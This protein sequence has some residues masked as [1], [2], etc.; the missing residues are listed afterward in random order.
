MEDAL[1]DLSY[2]DT[3][4][5]QL[6][7]KQQH[8]QHQQQFQ[9]QVHPQHQAPSRPQR[10]PQPSNPVRTSQPHMVRPAAAASAPHAHADEFDA[11]LL[12]DDADVAYLLSL[13]EA[14]RQGVL[15]LRAE[16]RKQAQ[17]NRAHSALA[18]RVLASGKSFVP[19][20][21]ASKK[22]QPAASVVFRSAGDQKE[23]EE[24]A[25][26]EDFEDYDED[27]DDEDYEDEDEEDEDWEGDYSDEDEEDA[28]ARAV[29]GAEAGMTLYDG[30]ALAVEDS[31][32]QQQKKQLKQ[33]QQALEKM[34]QAA[35]QQKNKQQQQKQAQ[36]HQ[37][38]QAQQKA[39]PK[40]Q[41][42]AVPT[43]VPAAASGG[44][45]FTLP[46]QEAVPDVNA[47]VYAP[48]AGGEGGLTHSQ[49]RALRR[50]QKAQEDA[51]LQAPA[52]VAAA[53]QLDFGAPAPAAQQQKKHAPA[54][55]PVQAAASTV[56]PASASSSVATPA[57]S[58]NQNHSRQAGGSAARQQHRGQSFFPEHLAQPVLESGLR[59]GLYLR[60]VLRI[61]GNNAFVTVAGV[62]ND[63]FIEGRTGRNRAF[64]G[65]EVCIQIVGEGAAQPAAAASAN[66]VA[67]PAKGGKA[68]ARASMEASLANLINA[69]TRAEE[70]KMATQAFDC[71][72]CTFS[73]DANAVKCGM[74]GSKRPKPAAAAAAPAR[75]ADSKEDVEDKMANLHLSDKGR[76]GDVLEDGPSKP[77]SASPAAQAFIAQLG[78][79]P[80]TVQFKGVVLGILRARYSPLHAPG[81]LFPFSEHMALF[82]PLDRKTP[83]ALVKEADWPAQFAGLYKQHLAKQ[84]A[85]KAA[86]IAG[87][88]AV[89]RAGNFAPSPENSS[90]IVLEPSPPSESE[91]ESAAVEVDAM[92]AASDPNATVLD[93][94]LY[95]AAYA[96]WGTTERQPYATVKKSLGACGAIGAET[97]ALLVANG[98]DYDL[99]GHFSGEVLAEVASYGANWTIPPA[100]LASRRDL[101]DQTKWRIVSI[102]PTTA[103]D[104]DDAIHV[105]LLP[106]G[107]TV[108]VGVHI[109]DV[110][111]FVRPG[112]KLDAE[113]RHRATTIYL[114]QKALPMLP[115][116][117]CEQLCSLN[118]NQDRLA[119]ST[120]FHLSLSSGEV[121]RT[122]DLKPWF[123]RTII[124]T[125]C[126]LN[127]ET[128]QQLMD[129]DLTAIRAAGRTFQESDLEGELKQTLAPGM[130]YRPVDCVSFAQLVDDMQLLHRVT[131]RRRAARFAAG[132]LTLSNVKLQFALDASRTEATGFVTYELRD[133]NR[134]VE[135]AMLLANMLVAEKCVDACKSIALLRRH[136]PPNEKSM[137]KVA[138]AC[139]ELGYDIDASTAGKL[140][141]S[142]SSF[143]GRFVGAVHG[144]NDENVSPGEVPLRQ[145]L[146]PMCTKPMQLARYF[147]TGSLADNPEEWGHYAL[148][149]ER[150]THF[151]SPIRRYADVIVHRVL[152][153]ALELDAWTAGGKAG[154][155]PQPDATLTPDAVVEIADQ[156][157]TRKAAAKKAQEASSKLFLCDL[158][159]RAHTPS[160]GGTPLCSRAILTDMF[161][162]EGG[163]DPCFDVLLPAMGLEKKIHLQD[164]MKNKQVQWADIT[165]K[166][167]PMP[168]QNN[169]R[170][171]QAG[172]GASARK[173][174]NNRP[175]ASP[176]SSPSLGAASSPSSSPAPLKSSKR[177]E[178]VWL[179]GS[180]NSFALFDCIDVE[181]A[182]RKGPPM[183]L[184]AFIVAP[185]VVEE[186]RRKQQGGETAP[187]DAAIEPASAAAAAPAAV[188]APVAVPDSAS[189]LAAAAKPV[190][191]EAAVASA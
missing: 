163:A 169:Q 160:S 178:V 65:D 36:Q 94:T 83:F 1:F 25:E 59:N 6:P 133:S 24:A 131:M 103:R 76:T 171:N 31:R 41:K 105:A 20:S 10:G 101:R 22:Q 16:Q 15:L 174:P 56:P 95:V 80:P 17:L 151:T 49:L 18:A 117:L 167:P 183:D 33:K 27:E 52:P 91:P 155:K 106:D 35:A 139:A 110:S 8:F 120:I 93:A 74:C 158:L 26:E 86:K 89:K 68:A 84:A 153:L 104:L 128:A 170:S 58:H 191:D 37:H 177:L 138:A 5:F 141:A 109:A 118:P 7:S 187:G 46:G 47:Y 159:L 97:E 39:A 48:P 38:Q 3:S 162:P 32:Q 54:P 62:R 82:R 92:T 125:C 73:N 137:A 161:A 77:A 63:I 132:S 149:F 129:L 34:Q 9:Q 51:G 122:G 90:D 157:N 189:L 119:Y 113:A 146:E 190:A 14:E 186:R 107:D 87:R 60:G 108:E 19:A 102:D 61:V 147:C 66:A 181:L 123:G 168:P 175:G 127:Y 64:D 142:L 144:F 11:D 145:V 126:R 30:E 13:G 115:P 148:A 44:L 156:C 184:D 28:V 100:E 150:Y 112:T 111:A 67:T 2:S 130:P 71:A 176:A 81:L 173:G 182:V 134:V 152:T 172:A 116:I 45:A 124:R 140:Q 96:A 98:V 88:L 154:P 180:R 69:S 99:D 79:A 42:A 114:V 29:H 43:P 143:E 75:P 23:F 4:S 121:I 85:A 179:D 135:E 40:K 185:A 78:R 166:D 55:A 12:G 136:P 70:E 57:R 50:Q 165:P 53:R 164:L 21:K 188:S 72:V